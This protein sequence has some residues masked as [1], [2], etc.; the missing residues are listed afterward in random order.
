MTD[1]AGGVASLLIYPIV[2]APVRGL[3]FD[4]AQIPVDRLPEIQAP[5][6]IF[7]HPGDA[8]H[9][10]RS[11]ELLRASVPGASLQ[12]APSAEHWKPNPDQF[13]ELVASFV[14]GDSS[15]TNC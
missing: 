2:A 3:L 11:A 12:V 7:G 13:S 4:G 8:M 14:K 1:R 6:L 10:L 5:T 15:R 9:P